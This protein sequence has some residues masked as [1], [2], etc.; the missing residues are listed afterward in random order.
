ML[1]DRKAGLN[2]N[3]W[4]GDVEMMGRVNIRT[5]VFNGGGGG[6]FQ[7]YHREHQ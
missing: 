2:L 4:H 5:A 7:S 6:P 3:R 1:G